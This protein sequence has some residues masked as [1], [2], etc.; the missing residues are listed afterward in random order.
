[1]SY[2]GLFWVDG[3]TCVV[4][5]LLFVYLLS[6]RKAG[7]EKKQENDRVKVSPFKDKAYLVF[8]G[9]LLLIG[10]TFLQYFSTIPLYYHDVHKL[11]EKEIGWLMALNG[12]LIF[13]IE[14]PLVSFFESERFSKFRILAISTL[15]F[16][17]SFFVLNMSGWVGVLT[18]GMIFM[19]FAEMLNFPFLNSF[20]MDRA[21]KFNNQAD[22]MA[23]F[24]MTFSIAHILGH[25]SGMHLVANFGYTITWYIMGVLLVI[26]VVFLVWL[27]NLIKKEK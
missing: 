11:T 7:N 21:E 27:R 1:V 26:S 2:A 20:A 16:A 12:L 10:F 19:S 24:T 17:F 4:A 3:I 14:M 18:I 13:V 9:A 23:L 25:N 5:S 6:E 22:Y 8:L 15:L